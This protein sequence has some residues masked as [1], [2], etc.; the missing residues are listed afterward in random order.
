MIVDNK[1][2]SKIILERLS[3]QRPL[4]YKK[5]TEKDI[6]SV[7]N[8]FNRVIK[9]MLRVGGF[10]TLAAHKGYAMTSHIRF[11]FRESIIVS[12]RYRQNRQV[13][14]KKLEEWKAM[15]AQESNE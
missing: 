11:N 14:F 13:Y 9:G 7:L 4:H 1:Y 2:F 3:S 8:H 15:K 5:F 6:E 10:I 12:N